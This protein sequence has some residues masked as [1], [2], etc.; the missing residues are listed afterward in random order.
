MMNYVIDPLKGVDGIQFGMTPEH[1]RS[2]M[3]ADFQSF[4][5]SPQASF[6]CDYFPGSG[7]FFYY[8]AS[9]L[10]EAVEFAAPARP[11]VSGVDLMNLTFEQA[12]KELT[13]LD[14]R[15]ETEPDGAIA[16]ELG[17]SIYA[18]LAK[19]NGNAPVESVVAFRRGYY[20]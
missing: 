15:V 3:K 12:I 9:G 2:R 7:T 10:L 19:D 4:K 14:Q 6:P 8:D 1:V 17:I 11:T 13:A 5:R 18:P 16:Y 20:N